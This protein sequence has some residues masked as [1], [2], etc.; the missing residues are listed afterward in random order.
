MFSSN[1]C[2]VITTKKTQTKRSCSGRRKVM[3]DIKMDLHKKIKSAGN[4]S[5]GNIKYDIKY[6]TLCK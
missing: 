4:N 3:P 5:R 6:K 2:E 1:F